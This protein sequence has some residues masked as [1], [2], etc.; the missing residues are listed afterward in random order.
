MAL[1]EISSFFASL[2]L[3]CNLAARSVLSDN[4]VM[5]CLLIGLLSFEIAPLPSHVRSS[6][7][8]QH[9]PLHATRNFVGARTLNRQQS[10]E[11]E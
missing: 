3:F 10:L 1:W 2:E 4:M 11:V 6:D 8:P 7:I 9:T 5:V